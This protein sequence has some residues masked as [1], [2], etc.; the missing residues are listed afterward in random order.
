VPMAGTLRKMAGTTPR[1]LIV[2]GTGLV[3]GAIR[4]GLSKRSAGVRATTRH[5]NTTAVSNTEWVQCDVCRDTLPTNLFADIQRAFLMAPT[6]HV[7]QYAVL[8]PLILAAKRAGVERIVL[9]S[10]QGV[11]ASDEIPFRKAELELRHAGIDFAIIRPAWFMQNFHTFW[12]DAIRRRGRIELPAGKGKVVFVDT[13]DVAAVAEALLTAD[14]I[15]NCEIDVTGQEALDHAQAAS[16]LSDATG[17][18]IEYE[19]IEPGRFLRT[20]IS[21]GIAPDYAALIAAMFDE[22]R[23]GGPIRTTDHVQRL[24][25]CAP[26]SLFSYGRDHSEQLQPR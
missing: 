1:F 6:G 9:M 12:G 19:D 4:T 7:D 20:L 16:I 24:T 25:G 22:V 2:G 10:A 14:S 3:G 21:D 8:S 5:P 11:D 13:R 23:A 18:K 17:N 26:R 15:E